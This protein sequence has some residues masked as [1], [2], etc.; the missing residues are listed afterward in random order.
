MKAPCFALQPVLWCAVLTFVPTIILSLEF[1]RSLYH[2]NLAVLRRMPCHPLFSHSPCE[3]NTSI[4]SRPYCPERTKQREPAKHA[5]APVIFWS[6]WQEIVSSAFIKKKRRRPRSA[7]DWGWAA[8]TW[9]T[10]NIFLESRCCILHM[11]QTTSICSCLTG[12]STVLVLY[13]NALWKD[14]QPSPENICHHWW[15]WDPMWSAFISEPLQSEV[16]FSSH[17]SHTM[18][19]L[20]PLLQMKHFPL[21]VSME[22]YR[23]YLTGSW[24]SREDFWRCWSQRP[25]AKVYED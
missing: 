20:L 8:K 12:L 18:K 6:T 1:L 17:K 3:H 15:H 19:S 5:T 25:R 22:Q 23:R 11:L 4:T 13:W 10:W 16:F 2:E 7:E 21:S 14:L 24:Q 9:L